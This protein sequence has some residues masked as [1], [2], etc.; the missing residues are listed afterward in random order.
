MAQRFRDEYVGADL[1]DARRSDRLVQLGAALAT[2]PA[3]SFP[4]ALGDGA[5]LEAAYRFFSN[6]GVKVD[7]V[8]E[9]HH[10]ETTARCE[11]K[12][13]VVVAHDTT[14]FVFQGENRQGLGRMRGKKERGFFSHAAL[15]VTSDGWGEPLGVLHLESWT[16]KER[17]SK[18]SKMSP[19]KRQKMPDR[20]STRWLRGVEAVEER[21]TPGRAIHVMDREAD[22]Y[23]LFAPLVADHCRFVIRSTF[24][25]KLADGGKLIDYVDSHDVVVTREVALSKRKRAPF[26]SQRKIHP[27]RNARIAKLGL[28]AVPVTL[29]R[30]RD[31]PANLPKSLSLHVVIV[32]EIDPPQGEPAISWR[33]Y[34]TEPIETASDIEFVVDAYRCRWRIEEFF[35]ALKTGC[36][37][38]KRQLE[39]CHALMNALAVFIPIAWR[40]LRHRTLAHA[41]GNRPA[42][43]ILT[44]LQIQILRKKSPKKLP[45]SLSVADA[46]VAVAALGGHLKR[47][48][49]PGW[50]TLSRGYEHLLVLE[51]GALLA[52]EM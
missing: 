39:S 32:E 52:R 37:I 14:D 51:E 46:L 16:R 38:Q 17:K 31:V 49:P 6:P 25:R 26:P 22:A 27:P 40:V 20:E 48:G 43:T 1:G 47:N 34:T 2:F 18:T 33:L 36:A 24:D 3:V 41:D 19:R 8:L 45:R 42:K 35:K 28:K 13:T 4:D 21:L 15:G 44:P 7:A 5:Q 10:R 30:P 29:S 50:I 11:K 12:E 9:P 23:E